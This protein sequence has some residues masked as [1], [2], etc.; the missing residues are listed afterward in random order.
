MAFNGPKK[1]VFA[2]G[3]ETQ[4]KMKEALSNKPE[5]E[6]SGPALGSSMPTINPVEKEKVKPFTFTL[7]PSSRKELSAIAK[8][9]GFRSTSAF[10]DAWIQAN[11]NN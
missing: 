7:K 2:S 1:N 6:T 5:V 9:H 11:K 4:A 3:K 10:L 8:R